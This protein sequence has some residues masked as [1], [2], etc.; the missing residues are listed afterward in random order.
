MITETNQDQ[1]Q[2]IGKQ[3]DKAINE[4]TMNEIEKFTDLTKVQS[5]SEEEDGFEK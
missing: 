1:K 3:L 2:E 4:M 5:S